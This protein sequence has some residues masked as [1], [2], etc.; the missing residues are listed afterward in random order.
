[1]TTLVINRATPIDGIL[2]LMG[3]SELRI[4]VDIEVG[5]GTIAPIIDF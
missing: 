5:R 4:D 3:A 2:S 1:M